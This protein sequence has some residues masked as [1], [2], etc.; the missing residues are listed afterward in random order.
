MRLEQRE[1]VLKVVSVSNNVLLLLGLR[2][3]LER[4]AGIL[5]VGESSWDS[6]TGNVIAQQRPDVILV[7]I[8]SDMKVEAI[9]D[10]RPKSP[11]S[12]IIVLSGWEQVDCA[13]QALA[14]GAD[15]IVMKFQ[16]P[17]ALLATVELLGKFAASLSNT[18]NQRPIAT[19]VDKCNAVAEPMPPTDTLTDR[20]REVILLV[21]RGLSNRDIAS[22][23]CLSETTIRHHLTSIFDKIGV[24]SRQKLLIYAYQHGLVDLAASV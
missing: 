7:D 22:E 23:L 20:E 17:K 2:R 11:L 1:P 24:S 5:V 6:A 3:I 15:T 14:A 21:R 19:T 4:H 10:L 13:R 18:V 9:N 8:E 16:H 12:R